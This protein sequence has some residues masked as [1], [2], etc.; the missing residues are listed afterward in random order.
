MARRSVEAFSSGELV[1]ALGVTFPDDGRARRE[2]DFINQ[3]KVEMAGIGVNLSDVDR[4]EVREL[5]SRDDD[6]GRLTSM[7]A[8]LPR[9][10]GR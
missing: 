6:A 10:S 1:A 4:W 9:R 5:V 3:A 2:Y 8:L 7:G